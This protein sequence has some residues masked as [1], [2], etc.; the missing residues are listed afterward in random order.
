MNKFAVNLIDIMNQRGVDSKKLAIELGVR[1]S[2]ISRWKNGVR[3]PCL[4]VLLEICSVLE[5]DPTELLGYNSGM[6][7]HLYSN[8]ECKKLNKTKL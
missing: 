4:D 1:Q 6:Q 2:T 8:R 7:E 3:E 5:V